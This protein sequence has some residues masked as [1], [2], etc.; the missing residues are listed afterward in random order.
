MRRALLVLLSLCGCDQAKQTSPAPARVVAVAA[1]TDKNAAEALC[2]VRFAADKAPSFALPPVEGS[3]PE[4]PGARW[5]NLWATWC[6]PCIEE[7]PLLTRA[8]DAMRKDKLDVS[9]VL[10]SVDAT[11]ETMKRFALSHHEAKASL[12]LRDPAALEPFLTGIGLDKGA[13]L[14]VHVLVDAGGKVRCVRTGAIGER[15]LPTVRA[16]LSER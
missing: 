4:T 3:P 9:L 5:V 7:L 13:T 1:Q 11:A 16:L 8:V 10:L 2:D 14:P 15:D 6:P 12:R